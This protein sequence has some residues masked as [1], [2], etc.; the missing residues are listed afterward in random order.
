MQPDH[1]SQR[2][3]LFGNCIVIDNPLN[4]I[5]SFDAGCCR[6][7]R[8]LRTEG[9]YAVILVGDHHDIIVVDEIKHNITVS[10]VEVRHDRRKNFVIPRQESQC[11]CSFAARQRHVRNVF[12]QKM[13]ID[14]QEIIARVA[15]D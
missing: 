15:V 7:T 10:G 12:S 13:C 14:A 3:L 8:T 2:R 1:V 9:N 11:V 5:G 4:F 6:Q